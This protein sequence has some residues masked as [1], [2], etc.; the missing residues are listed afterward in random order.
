[1]NKFQRAIIRT[2]ARDLLHKHVSRVAVQVWRPDPAD[3]AP[4]REFRLLG[5]A[6][7]LFPA[8]WPQVGKAPSAGQEAPAFVESL[9]WGWGVDR[10]AKR[11]LAG[12]DSCCRAASRWSRHDRDGMDTAPSST[13]SHLRGVGGGSGVRE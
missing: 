9:K 10:H 5:D 6:S 2:T 11:S 12:P 1:M 7:V 8:R 3:S 13:Q 4:G